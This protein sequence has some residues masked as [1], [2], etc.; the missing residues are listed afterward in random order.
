MS[1][2]ADSRRESG[3]GNIDANDPKPT[4]CKVSAF[5][6]EARRE[7]QD[8]SYTLSTS[9]IRIGRLRTRSPVA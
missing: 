3:R 8:Q 5:R 9:S 6:T 2:I 1:G 7:A 4:S